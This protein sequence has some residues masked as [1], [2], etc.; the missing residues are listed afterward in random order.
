MAVCLGIIGIFSNLLIGCVYLKGLELGADLKGGRL[1]LKYVGDYDVATLVGVW[2]SLL[3]A[4]RTFLGGWALARKWSQELI[5]RPTGSGFIGLQSMGIFGQLGTT[6]KTCH[7]LLRRRFPAGFSVIPLMLLSISA[8]VLQTTYSAAVNTLTI[9]ILWNTTRVCGYPGSGPF[10]SRPSSGT[11]CETLSGE[12]QLSCL[13][14]WYTS[15][16]ISNILAYTE[17]DVST[18]GYLWPFQVY[19]VQDD[20]GEYHSMDEHVVW[21]SGRLRQ[22]HKARPRLICVGGPWK[23]GAPLVIQPRAVVQTART[24]NHPK[25]APSLRGTGTNPN[26]CPRKFRAARN[27]YE[28]CRQITNRGFT[29]FT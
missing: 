20:A 28:V 19:R 12:N 1:K 27:Q 6:L 26:S 4:I 29:R 8:I 21:T 14:N 3:N 23:A 5:D 7:S 22:W 17:S 18:I 9:P 25:E 13:Q 10:M 11:P 15:N 16:A 2:G 24:I